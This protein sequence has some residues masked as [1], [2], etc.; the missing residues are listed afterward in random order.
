MKAI[1]IYRYF[2]RFSVE[3]L[4]HASNDKAFLVLILAYLKA[5]KMERMHTKKV[6]VKC[7]PN[8][9]RALENL[10]NE[11]DHRAQLIDIVKQ[12]NVLRPSEFKINN[13]GLFRIQE[14]YHLNLDKNI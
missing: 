6:F 1:E 9:Y 12:A 7:L 11:S 3:K 4:L 5:T 8:Y 14:L 2:Y 10:I 13:E